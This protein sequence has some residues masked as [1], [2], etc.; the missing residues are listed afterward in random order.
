MPAGGTDVDDQ[1][2]IDP[3]PDRAAG[4][5]PAP[6]IDKATLLRAQEV[7]AAWAP[8]PPDR[9]A[10]TARPWVHPSVRRDEGRLQRKRVPR[11]SHAAFAPRPDRDPISILAAQEADRLQTLIPLRH[12]RMSESAFA[13]Y[14]GTPAV[15][16]Y[17]LAL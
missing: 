13:Y 10:W 8:G 9:D 16:A 1:L 2:I 14:R 3:A 17:D 11:A 4:P 5:A 12:Q 6:I 7:E 15:M